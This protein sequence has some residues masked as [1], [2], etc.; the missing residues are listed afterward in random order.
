[1]LTLKYMATSVTYANSDT[2]LL[3]TGISSS[4]SFCIL[5]QKKYNI[6]GKQWKSRVIDLNTK[7]HLMMK[8]SR[9]HTSIICF[10]RMGVSIGSSYN[11]GK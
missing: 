8:Y 6:S 7:I 5:K 11:I 4:N 2:Y 10:R 3:S 9:S 1:M